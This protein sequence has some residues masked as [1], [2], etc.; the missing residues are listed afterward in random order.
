MI[1]VK[2][3]KAGVRPF[4]ALVTT[5]LPAIYGKLRKQ[6]NEMSEIAIEMDNEVVSEDGTSSVVIPASIAIL[7]SYEML[8]ELKQYRSTL[9][10]KIAN[11]TSL[12]PIELRKS[13]RIT[14]EDGLGEDALVNAIRRLERLFVTKNVTV[15]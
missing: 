8:D 9:E 13:V 4:P 6:L 3:I 1:A 5:D 10:E 14:E 7:D 15:A 12:K 2:K 11:T